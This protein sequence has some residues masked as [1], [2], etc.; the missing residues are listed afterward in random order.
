M[1]QKAE[2]SVEAVIKFEQVLY[3]V[4]QVLGDN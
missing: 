1:I 2:D 3:D 4:K